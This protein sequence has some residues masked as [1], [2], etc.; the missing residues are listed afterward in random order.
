VRP[1]ICAPNEARD[2]GGNART[3]TATRWA[4]LLVGLVALLA[5]SI[6]FS[7]ARGEVQIA[8]TDTRQKIVVTADEASTWKEGD[9]KNP[10]EIWLLKGNCAIAQ[11]AAVVRGQEAVLWV[12]RQGELGNPTHTVIAYV[13]G[14]VLIE[15]HTEV[16]GGANPSTPSR[17]QAITGEASRTGAQPKPAPPWYGR[18][19]CDYPPEFEIKAV[20]KTDPGSKPSIY[21]RALERRLPPE[22]IQRTQFA[23]FQPEAIATPPASVALAGAR[24]VQVFPRSAVPLQARYFQNPNNPNESVAV[25]SGGVQFRIDGFGRQLASGIRIGETLDIVAD[26]VVIWTP[27]NAQQ[28]LIGPSA[29]PEN[30]PLEL[31]LEGDIIFREGDRIVYAQSMYYNVPQRTGIILNAEA[32]TPVPNYAG[33]M[34]LR[35]NVLRQVGMDR[36]IAEGAS[37]TTSRLAMPTY[38]FRAGTLMLVDAQIPEVDP[39]T[40]A[41][42]LNPETGN[43]LN[44]HVQTVTS[45]NNVVFVEGVPVFYWPTL[46]T[47]AREPTFYIQK[48]TVR[49][50][51]IFGT[52]IETDW[53]MYQLLGWQNPPEGTDW[54]LSLDYLSERGPAAGTKFT[55]DQDFLFKT[56]RRTFG[57]LDAWFIDDDGLDTLGMD[58]VGIPPEPDRDFRGRVLGRHRQE[59]ENNWQLSAE[60][61]YIT[62]RNFLEQFFEKE[63]DELADQ[64]TGI[65]LKRTLDNSALEIAADV[66]LNDFFLQTEQF[67]RVDHFWIGQS[68]W[69]DRLTW[70]EHTSVGFFRQRPAS[71]PTDP[72]DAAT[73][74]LLPYEPLIEA[75]GER[76]VTRQALELPI[77]AGPMK[78][79]PFVLGEAGHWGEVLDQDELQRVY[80]QAG[81]RTSLP[82]WSANP[83][84]ES[85]LFNVHGLAHKITLDGEFSFT[86]AS[87]DLSQFPLYDEIDDDNIQAFRRRLAFQTFGGPPPVPAR[88]DERF[89]AVRRGLMDNVTGPTEIADDLTVFRIGARQR[90][91][92][93]RGPLDNRRIIDWITLDT[94]AE[95]F[96][97][98]DENFGENVGLVDYDFRWH[99]GDRLTLLSDGAADFFGQGGKL[100]S[101]GGSLN[102]PPRGNLYLGFRSLEGPITSNVLLAS[103]SY[104]MT[105]KWASSFGLSYDLSNNGAM[106]ETLTLTRIGESFL[107][108]VGFN[109]DRGRDNVGVGIALEPRFLPR[110]S[111]GRRTGITVPVAG[112]YGIE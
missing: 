96:P 48:A 75:E 87:E 97:D 2:A 15:Q 69:Q 22:G 105:P 111:F 46:A 36:F 3:P 94:H 39:L 65:E 31:Y 10:V 13:D 100:F 27:G 42:V 81:L 109:A 35:A 30:M 19:Y 47:D 88:F 72:Q 110:T 57:L 1:P 17:A 98:E 61:G 70:Y 9:A 38:E 51:D 104:R 53:N 62:D 91:Q 64:R 5:W 89:Y 7:T 41:P 112:T 23:E 37:V 92:T 101:V 79:V 68:L 56:S 63:W 82:F 99:V 107:F 52:S 54:S 29:E 60:V 43:P 83:M 106:G 8:A 21:H 78:V 71:V 25:I 32:L 59:L 85:D 77:D 58:R 90:W 76:F 14:Q 86:D 108:S 67:P 73:F 49:N 80:G 28:Y 33:L 103:Y 45:T 16:A 55:Y 95:V 11:G 18:L 84:I 24:N 74:A 34:R 93:R 102:R 44:R 6:P 40:G 20:S 66:R 12:E 50:D 26:R 4:G